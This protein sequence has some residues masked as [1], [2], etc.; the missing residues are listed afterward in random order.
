LLLACTAVTSALPDLATAEEARGVAAPAAGSAA[1]WAE[2]AKEEEAREEEAREEAARA[3]SLA[4]AATDAAAATSALPDLAFKFTAAADLVE[5]RVA[6]RELDREWQG[7]V[8]EAPAVK[9]KHDRHERRADNIPP[10]CLREHRRDMNMND[11]YAFIN[12]P[13]AARESDCKFIC[14]K[15]NAKKWCVESEF[16]T[17][18]NG[19]C[20]LFGASNEKTHRDMN[21]WYIPP[22]LARESDCAFICAKGS[23][24]AWCVESEFSTDDNGSCRLSACNTA[25]CGEK[26]HMN[27]NDHFRDQLNPRAA[28]EED[29]KFICDAKAWC[30]ESEFSTED[31]GSCRLSSCKAVSV[32]VYVF[33][34]AR[35]HKAYCFAVLA[36]ALLASAYL[37]QGSL[38]TLGAKSAKSS[39]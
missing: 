30:V 34:E 39:L 2:E 13:R 11:W 21:T 37:R 10:N 23:A 29:C 1:A 12:P 8:V 16:S 32:S 5:L 4:A 15:G 36:F 28:R 3:A 9:V 18:D 19:S 25:L 20:R 27:M 6:L 31:N 26:K 14:A 22:R 24:K 17:E 35:S 7:E 38:P 33:G